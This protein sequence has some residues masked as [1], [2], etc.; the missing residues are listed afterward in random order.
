MNR[1]N[2]TE[3]LSEGNL[4]LRGSLF[5]EALRGFQ[6]FFRGPLR[7]PLRGRFPSQRLSVLLPLIVLPLELSPTTY[8]KTLDTTLDTEIKAKRNHIPSKL[9]TFRITKANANVKFGVKYLCGYEC[10]SSSVQLISMRKTKANKYFLENEFHFNVRVNGN[11][12]FKARSLQC[13]LAAKLPNSDL[14]F[15]V[16]FWVDF[17]LM[18]FPGRKAPKM[19][20]RPG[21]CT[22]EMHGG[23]IASYLAGT[24]CVPLF[25][26]I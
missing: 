23:S 14:N 16:D 21:D 20:G 7:D 1:G 6:R 19:T 3:S 9:K 5:R 25:L 15:A 17:I 26:L 18:F 12:F 24:L 4:P 11:C 8:K 13:D 10:E 22:M 2:R